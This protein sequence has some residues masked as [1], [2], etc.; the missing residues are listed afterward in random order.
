MA[1]DLNERVDEV[2]NVNGRSVWIEGMLILSYLSA[3][4]NRGLARQIIQIRAHRK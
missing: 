2:R 3:G 1:N 4:L